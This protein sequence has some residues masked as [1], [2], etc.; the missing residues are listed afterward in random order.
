MVSKAASK[1]VICGVG[2]IGGS[3]AL[4]V[5]SALAGRRCPRIVG[6]GRTRAPL[7][8]ALQLGVIDAIADDW[9]SA[10]EG[11]DLVLLG[12]PVGQM[13]PVMQAMAPHLEP[14]TVVSDG[15]STK[16][17][18]VAAA[19]EAFGNKIGQFVPGHPIAGAEQSGVAAAR[20]ELYLD[21]RVVLTPLPENAPEAVQAVRTVWEICGAKV[22]E[23]APAEHDRVFAAV[24]HLPH[25]LAFALVHDLAT[26]D[27][28]DQLF[29]FA[30]SGFRDFTRIASSHPEMWRDICLANRNALLKEL[31]AYMMELMKARVLLASEDS[32]GL[33]EMFDVARTRRDA[34]LVAME[35]AG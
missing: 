10:L 21:K 5:K 3:F 22:S 23:L 6:M 27:N 18:V 20:A 4:A 14:H 25:L 1:V 26:R 13:A 8:Q 24:S 11:A 32:A 17:D 28:A 16:S 12:M 9:A 29:G 15:G 7:E 30:A 35:N 31:D 2:L 33:E 34:W 19:R